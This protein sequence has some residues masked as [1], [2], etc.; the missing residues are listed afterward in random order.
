MAGLEVGKEGTTCSLSGSLYD[1][2][3]ILAI[4]STLVWRAIDVDSGTELQAEA[5]LTPASQFEIA[6]PLAVNTIEDEA[7][8]QETRRISIK[9]TYAGG[10]GLTGSYDYLLKNM[11]GE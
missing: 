8:K 1:K 4:P 6:V 9:A 3:D 11:S 5:A 10:E 2:D 7:K